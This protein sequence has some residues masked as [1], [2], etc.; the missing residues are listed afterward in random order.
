MTDKTAWGALLLYLT[1][2]SAFA[3][4]APIYTWDTVAYLATLL[5]VDGGDPETLHRSTYTLLEQRLSAAQF[6][7]LVTG[8]YASDLL[9]NAAHFYGQLNMYMVKPLYVVLLRGLY[10]LGFE[11]ILALRLMSLLPILMI[12]VLLLRW[13]LELV[14][15]GRALLLLI[16]FTIA[17]RLPLLARVPLPDPLSSLL[18][19]FACYLLL[20]RDLLLP[21]VVC[22]FL[23]VLTRSNNIILVVLV[24]GALCWL[25]YRRHG[26]L[27][28]RALW[29]PAAGLLLSVAAYLFVAMRYDQGWWPLFYHSFVESQVDPGQ[30]DAPFSLAI[31]LRVVGDA[32]AQ[33]FAGSGLQSSVLLPF[34]LLGAI[35]MAG[36]W[37]D[38]V[39]ALWQ[40]ES[41]RIHLHSLLLLYLLVLGAFLLLFPM[42]GSWDRFLTPLYALISLHATSRFSA[43]N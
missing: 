42:V 23:A 9:S 39:R 8:P 43:D 32:L 10:L 33:L 15:P 37:K 18:I 1:G 31:Y 27:S 11:P 16:L 19:L 14:S 34:L 28:A 12:C 20:Q 29:L 22:F 5:A 17:A 21:A 2:L 26:R 4:L 36:H 24:L 38:G 41:A 35:A 7:Q 30:F 13:F 3:L 40:P 6:A 25:G